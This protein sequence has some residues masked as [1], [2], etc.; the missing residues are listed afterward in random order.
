MTRLQKFGGIAALIE[1][2][3]YIAGF[4]LYAMVL[5]SSGYVGPVRK[6]AFLLEHQAA[7]R[8]GNLLIYI[9]FGIFLV[10]LALALYE[11]LRKAS[12]VLSQ[13]ATAFGLIW[14]GL[15]LASGMIFSVGMDAVIALSTSDM[16]EA[17]SL[18]RTVGTI[19][20]GLGGG[21]EIVGGLWLLLVSGAGW[22]SRALPKALNCLGFLIG[23]VGVLTVAP[24]ADSLVE[25][26][27]LSQII[28]F[29]WLGIIMLRQEA[30]QGQQT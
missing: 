28:W 18:L 14:A 3:A 25:V 5:D 12:P 27:G 29:V 15:V 2:A 6:V 26:F 8:L 24:D 20:N 17:A 21:I 30:N 10:V 7:N 1:A 4:G 23:A 19:Q 22:H 16:P 11:R 13:M 9:I